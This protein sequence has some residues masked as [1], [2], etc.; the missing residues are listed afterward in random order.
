[1]ASTLID[2]SKNAANSSDSLRTRWYIDDEYFKVASFVQKP[3]FNI[4][5]LIFALF[6]SFTRTQSQKS[7]LLFND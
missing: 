5:I 1:M 2:P 6:A 4:A 7:P 3:I